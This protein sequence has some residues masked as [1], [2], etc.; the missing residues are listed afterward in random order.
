MFKI[1]GES[2]NFFREFKFALYFSLKAQI[3][4]SFDKFAFI[5]LLKFSSFAEKVDLLAV[6]S[7]EKS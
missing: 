6:K 4:H 5:N 1:L 3:Y 7:V 2:L